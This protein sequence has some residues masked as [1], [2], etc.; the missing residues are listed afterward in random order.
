M[1][2][3]DRS[4][5]YWSFPL[6][7]VSELP[8]DLGHI[9]ISIAI[10]FVSKVSE[11]GNDEATGDGAKPRALDP[12][13]IRIVNLVSGEEVLFGRSDDFAHGDRGRVEWVVEDP[14][15]TKYEVSFKAVATRPALEP[16]TWVPM[17][18]VGDLLRYNAGEPRP[19]A[20]SKP[21]RLID[22]TGDGKPDLAGCWNY[23]Y[24][25]GDPISGVACFPRVGPVED[26]TFG[27]MA[28]LR[29][30]DERG[31]QELHHFPGVYTEAD[32]ADLDGDGLPDIVFAD[33]RDEAV[34]VYLNTG[35]RD[36]GG[37]PIFVKDMEIPAP[38][39]QNA[40]I[41]VVDL[42]G[43]GV[44]DLVV[45]G[46][47]VRNLNPNRWPFEP[48]EPV[49]LE[50]GKRL[51]FIDLSGDGRLDA[52]S[53]PVGGYDQKLVGHRNKGGD[54]PDFGYAESLQGID[55]NYCSLACAVSDG[56]RPGVL[57]QHNMYQHLSFFE[58]VGEK[59]GQPKFSRVGRAESLSAVMSFSDQAW[60]CMCDWNGDGVYDLVIGGGYGWPRFVINEGTN[61][62]PVW[63]EPE[64]ILS[65]GEPIRI[66]RDEILFS[67]HWHNMGYPYPTFVDWDGDGLPDLM[68]PNETNRLLWYKNVGSLDKP[69]FGPRQFLEVDGFPDSEALRR[70]TGEKTMGPGSPTNPFDERWPFDYRSGVAFADWNGDG[71][72]DFIAF[73]NYRKAALFVQYRDESGGLGLRLEGRVK[74]ADGR[75]LDDSIVGRTKHWTQSLRAVDWDGDGRID[76]VY[77]V[78]AT[79][80]IYLLRNLGTETMPVFDAPREFKYYGEEMGFTIHGP[81]AWA[82][83]FNGDGKP[84]LLG[85]VE[86]SVYPFFAHAALAMDSHPEYVIGDVKPV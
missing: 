9:P 41:C 24:R 45:N 22:L 86:W 17:I 73:D 18:G 36:D 58:L 37:L 48:A 51:S 32:F 84:D 81:N 79:G 12:N 67:E 4:A 13:S 71:L 26:F 33:M 7:I 15:H 60:P 31:S 80:K 19:I 54:P 30:V 11:A 77:S 74:L 21:T 44:L 82:G 47:F 66:Q 50:A 62:R 61:K 38:V 49:D 23:Y 72:M 3:D 83:D 63:R 59:D 75:E 35:D 40:G 69:E 25:P 46:H 8:D 28:R 10:D 27:D 56:E 39:A 57:V 1:D 43:N 6:D 5:E 65:E 68:L 64:L 70:E 78:A 16:Q 14:S 55:L 2:S 29:Y 53:M 34:T 52:L 20:L 76:I 85:C 42:D